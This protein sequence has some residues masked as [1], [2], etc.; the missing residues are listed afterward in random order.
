MT[1]SITEK[2]HALARFTAENNEAAVRETL[3]LLFCEIRAGELRGAPLPEALERHC[4]RTLKVLNERAF[5]KASSVFRRTVRLSDLCENICLACDLLALKKGKRILFLG[6]ASPLYLFCDSAAISRAIIVILNHAALHAEGPLI[7]L[8]LFKAETDI[9]ITVTSS[10]L[11]SESILPDLILPYGGLSFA[12]AA[13]RAHGGQLLYR[14][15]PLETSAHLIM[16]IAAPDNDYYAEAPAFLSLL[17]D[18]LSL[19][20]VGFCE[21]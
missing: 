13:A 12:R 16:P 8:S 17:S 3:Q 2:L 20:Q 18:R 9:R 15:S 10:A 7:T 14:F 6:D 21:V 1:E 4:L 5:Q 19:V 11:S